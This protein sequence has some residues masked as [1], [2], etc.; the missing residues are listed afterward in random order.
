MLTGRLASV[1]ERF[2]GLNRFRK[3]FFRRQP[4]GL[5]PKFLEETGNLYILD[6]HPSGESGQATTVHQIDIRESPVKNYI[7]G[8]LAVGLAVLLSFVYR[9]SRQNVLQ[10]FPVESAGNKL[11]TGGARLYLFIFFSKNNC[12]VCLEAIRVLNGLGAPYV[13]TGI[14]PVKELWDEAGLRGVSGAEFPLVSIGREHV[15]FNP[16]YTPSIFG[17]SARGRILFVLPGVPGEGK[18]LHDFLT[19]VYSRTLEVLIEDSK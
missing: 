14:V 7:I 5:S 11:E 8:V 10:R 9:N 18:Y 17:V 16:H 15:K 6:T 2:G 19:N 1:I 13:V 4:T 12:H 3:G